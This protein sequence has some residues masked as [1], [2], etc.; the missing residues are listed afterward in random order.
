MKLV[1]L[2]SQ[3][4]WLHPSKKCEVLC[5][6]KVAEIFKIER[7]AKSIVLVFRYL[8]SNPI[9]EIRKTTEALGL[10]FGTISAVIKR[11]VDAGILA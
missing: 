8:E 10:P 2:Y 7:T 1:C 5:N 4:L 9:I 3:T 6:Q 11:S